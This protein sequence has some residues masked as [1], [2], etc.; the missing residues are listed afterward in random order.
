MAAGVLPIRGSFV[1]VIDR[2]LG[3]FKFIEPNA[4]C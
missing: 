4:F 2:W 1:P 3:V